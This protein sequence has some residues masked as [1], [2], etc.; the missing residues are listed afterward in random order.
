VT[1][2]AFGDDYPAVICEVTPSGLIVAR[3]DGALVCV[4][5]SDVTLTDTAH[6]ARVLDPQNASLP[7]WVPAEEVPV[8]TAYLAL[9]TDGPLTFKGTDA[10]TTV[11]TGRLKRWGVERK[12][13]F[14]IHP[15][16]LPEGT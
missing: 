10:P 12:A 1:R 3:A 8:G 16:N 14:L 7:R 11:M 13:F 2:P 4:S 9:I 5:L 6:L 15:A